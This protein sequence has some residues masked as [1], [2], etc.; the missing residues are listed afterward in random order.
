MR[1]VRFL[2]LCLLAIYLLLDQLFPT[3]WSELIVY[4]LIPTAA[5]MAIACAPHISDKIAK[6]SVGLAVTFWAL[7]SAVASSAIFFSSSTVA[8]TISNV[9]YLLFY[10]F[11]IIGLPRLLAAQRKLSLIELVDSSIFGLGL[12]TLGSAL[13]LKPVLPHFDGNLSETFFAIMYPAADLILVCVVIA[14]VAMQG[15]SL[16]GLVLSI[17]VIVFALN[18]IVYL[19]QNIHGS[20]LMGSILDIGWV[21]GLLIIAESF[22]QP[23]IDSKA[24]EGINPILISISV[25]LSATLLALIAMRPDYFPRFILIPAIAT[26]A[27]AFARMALALTQAKNIGQERLLARTDELTGLPNRRRLVTEI[28]AF[29]EKEGALL[30]LDLDGFK[31]INDVYGHETGDKILQQV[32]LRFERALPH[33][34][35]LARLGGDE[36]GVL[37]EGGH[38][39]AVEIALALRATLSYPFHINN[40]EIQLGVSIGVAKNTGEK[41]LLVRADKAMYKAKREGLGVYRL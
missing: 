21:V 28:D 27:L 30:L 18:D 12:S 20:Y 23:G 16:R 3:A 39:S 36:F 8:N 11:A 22:W 29:V 24:R 34:A 38:E 35:L 19:W 32:A 13:V 31:P 25:S 7:G 40:Q 15:Y 1:V 9:L 17:G 14:T 2:G 5:I 6:P 33:G 10:P 41:D 37:Y 26:L 4:N